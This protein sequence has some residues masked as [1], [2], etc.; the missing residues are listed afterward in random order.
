MAENLTGQVIALV[1][2]ISIAV[3]VMI[4]T[5]SLSGGVYE[6]VED[7]LSNIGA[8]ETESN[9]TFTALN[10]TAVSL[11]NYHI[12]IDT[13]T[14]YANA[15]TEVALANFSINYE[16]GTATLLQND[17]NNTEVNATYNF[18]NSTI[19][20]HIKSGIISGFD[21]QRKVGDMMPVIVLS[22]II[23]LVLGAIFSVTRYQL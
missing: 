5:S 20:E 22:I 2:G 19:E 7:D 3:L 1:A 18:R 6:T 14:L 13:L 12:A 11:G 21:G 8:I 4:F 9:Y 16:A 17:F 23:V 10:G 15:T